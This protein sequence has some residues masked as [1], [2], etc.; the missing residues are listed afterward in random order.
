VSAA[1]ELERVLPVLRAVR[2]AHPS[3]PIS[4]DTAKAAVAGPAME[5]GATAI[6]DVTALGDPELAPLV[7]RAGG[8]LMLMH[9]RGTPRTMQQ[10]PR[11][12]DVVAE[13]R[14]FLLE[15]VARAVRA[16]IP[17]ERLWVDPGIGFGKTV[18]HNLTLLR[19][20]PSL[21]ACGLP[22]LVGASRK[23]FI[24]HVLGLPDTDQRLEGSL[25]V[26]ALASWMGASMLRVHD[27]RATRRA[28][29]MAWA[30]RGGE[31]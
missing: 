30:L 12:D 9:M 25:A 27:V 20:L 21:V 2:R 6:N 5:A 17:Q 22:V 26:A 14:D 19:E 1:D 4:V 7:A 10:A 23:S 3:L 18:E 28:V 24:G 16:G 15:R 29:D 8:Q 31:A 11:Y 13:V